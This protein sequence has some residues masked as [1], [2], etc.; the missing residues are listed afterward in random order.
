MMKSKPILLVLV[1]VV[2]ALSAM[3]MKSVTEKRA[4]KERHAADESVLR[5]FST[6]LK[7]G[8]PRSQVEA[9]L[10]SRGR[11]FQQMCCLLDENRNALQDLVRIGSEP[12]AWYCSTS[13]MYLVFEFDS[14]P[15]P[16]SPKANPNDTLRKIALSPWQQGCL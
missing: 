6:A 10:D 2:A 3:L 16:R 11:S 15:D 8:T 14:L 12:K 9:L 5:E 13:D 4:G 7:P 1:V